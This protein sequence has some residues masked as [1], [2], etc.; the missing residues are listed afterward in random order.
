MKGS[1]LSLFDEY[2]L[3]EKNSCLSLQIN[4]DG[5][6][7]SKSS[8]AQFWP[9]L[10]MVEPTSKPV[11]VGLCF[12]DSKP[13][14]IDFLQPFVDEYVHLKTEGL[15][16]HGSLFQIVICCVVCD[17][18]AR[19]FFKAVKGHTGYFGCERCE[20]EGEWNRLF[21]LT[22]IHLS[23]MIVILIKVADHL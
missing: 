12:G 3:P 23:I 18:P 15:S 8:G 2:E 16:V 1:I 17:A 6:P 19:S 4:V 20:Q 11:I 13:S 10:C 7:I 9:V 21:F 14:S 22:W 5:L